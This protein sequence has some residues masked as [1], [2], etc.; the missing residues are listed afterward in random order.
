MMFRRLNGLG[1]LPLSACMPGGIAATSFPQLCNTAPVQRALR[2]TRQADANAAVFA[3]A[4]G[5]PTNA[6]TGA[7]TA[8]GLP[9]PAG[10]N[11]QPIT[12][13]PPGVDPTMLTADTPWYK[14]PLGIGALAL[15]GFLG[16][17]YYK[18]SHAA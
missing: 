16:Y 15:A 18:R 8:G 5:A 6:Q 10:I 12:A 14:T 11:P 9:L 7:R 1:D 2:T 4:N 17:R 13:L 3:I